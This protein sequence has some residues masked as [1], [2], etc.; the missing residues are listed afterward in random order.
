MAV[1]QYPH[2]IFVHLVEESMQDNE[3]NWSTPVDT[4]VKHCICREETNGAGRSIIGPDGNA[5]VFSSVVYAPRT[6]SRIKEGT[7]AIVSSTDIV[8]G[9]GTPVGEIRIKATIL[10]F[11]GAQLHA[12]IWL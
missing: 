6:A 8:S 9:D 4:W 5:I 7:E 3:G 10:K 11:D 12:R 2:F 1:K